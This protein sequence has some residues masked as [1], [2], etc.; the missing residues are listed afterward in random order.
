MQKVWR[1]RIGHAIDEY[2]GHANANV[3]AMSCV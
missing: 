2:D 3:I 1:T